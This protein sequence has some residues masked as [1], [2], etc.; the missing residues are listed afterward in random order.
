M[1]WKSI[2]QCSL[3][4]FVGLTYDS[5]SQKNNVYA[6]FN[7][8][9]LA[10]KTEVQHKGE[11]SLTS[12]IILEYY[13]EALNQ[14]GPVEI[15]FN[16]EIKSTIE[17]YINFRKKDIAVYLGRAEYYFPIIEQTLDKYNLPLELK[18]VAVIE[19]GLNPLAVSKSGAVGLWQF[20]YNTCS[21]FNLK[22]ESYIDERRDPYIATDA[23][24][25]YFQY[26][27]NTF[28]DWDLVL[29]SYNGGPGEVRKAIERSGGETD[30]WKIRPYLSK[31][32][33]EY[34]PVFAAVYY[35]MNYYKQYDIIPVKQNFAS[36][37]TDT[38]MINY[39][40]SFQQISGVIG[41]PIPVIKSLNPIY[42]SDYIPKCQ[43]FCK[44]ILP[45]SK[46]ADFLKYEGEIKNHKQTT[47]PNYLSQVENAGNTENRKKIEHIVERGEY[48]HKI[49]IQ[50]NCTIED[51]KAW[52]KIDSLSLH[53][54]QVLEIWLPIENPL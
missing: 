37:P 52:N 1:T 36:E 9:T 40:L 38:V 27:Y 41:I 49:A 45:E 28:H 47:K 11:T 51:I 43:N 5:Y 18:Y 19:S 42:K 26:L 53:P 31:Q 12:D 29:A 2:F 23:A 39:Q 15:D 7:D 34:V 54:G 33:T 32:A 13:I 46:I 30:Y 48:F 14:K 16:P 21:L 44:L 17:K 50:Y 8:S 10:F 20:L 24:C 35:L 3:L 22:V 6:K 25:R 4:F